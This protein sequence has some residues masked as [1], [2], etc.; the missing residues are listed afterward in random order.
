MDLYTLP[1]DHP[2]SHSRIRLRKRFKSSLQR[3]YEGIQ[4]IHPGKLEK[5]KPYVVAPWEPRIQYKKHIEN[6]KADAATTLFRE[7]HLLI[8]TIAVENQHG[9]AYGITFAEKSVWVARGERLDNIR[10]LNTYIA[11]LQAI[12]VA[13]RRA[14]DNAPLHSA[15]LITATNLA[16]LQVL[17]N[18]GKQSGQCIV[19]SIYNIKREMEQRGYKIYWKWLPASIPCFTRDKATEEAHKALK[20]NSSTHLLPQWDSMSLTLSRATPQLADKKTLPQGVGKIIQDLD[21]ALPGK[22]TKVIYNMDKKDAK[23]LI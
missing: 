1:A 11:E 19:H 12:A 14:K 9:I 17:S 21:T 22:H 6:G 8:I 3:I 23:I 13:L 16:V 20:R 18:P 5:I 15:I 4:G 7:H 10:I 2:L